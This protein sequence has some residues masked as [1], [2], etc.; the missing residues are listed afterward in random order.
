MIAAQ[1]SNGLYAGAGMIRTIVDWHCPS[2]DVR[3][4]LIALL[5]DAVC[6]GLEL[7][8]PLPAGP[9]VFLTNHQTAL[10]ILLFAYLISAL[11]RERI[12]LIGWEGALAMNS[13]ELTTALASRADPG[14]DDLNQHLRPHYID[15]RDPAQIV[16]T[17]SRLGRELAD[18]DAPASAVLAADGERQAT[19]QQATLRAGS[20]F[21]D[22]GQS[23]GVPIVPVRFVWGLPALAAGH[24]HVWPAGF[25]PQRY[26]VGPPLM[27]ED[28]NGQSLPERCERVRRA[29]DALWRPPP[30]GQAA[31]GASRRGRIERL[32]AM[33]G[34]SQTKALLCDLLL[35]A[36]PDGLS[37]EG[38][39]VRTWLADVTAADAHPGDDW[40]YDF[41]VWLSDGFN[42][43]HTPLHETYPNLPVRPS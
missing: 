27:P 30:P 38:R 7:T 39:T 42:T 14:A 34:M 2:A 23:F 28:L 24:R 32:I 5:Y 37:A 19:E 12:N 11:R 3:R 10:D 31:V 29:I 36:D 40:L 15:S 43:S 22:L 17:A 6:D 4:D 33:T 21:V 25:A 20:S 9:C 1:M 16:A 26:I 13:G 41:A 18:P 8:A 35:A